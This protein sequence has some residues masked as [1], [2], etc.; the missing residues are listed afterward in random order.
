MK[1]VGL[2]FSV[3]F[4]SFWISARTLSPVPQQTTN[5]FPAPDFVLTAGSSSS[6]VHSLSF[7]TYGKILAVG[8]L[9]A[10]VDLW[11][12]ASRKKLRSINAGPACAISSDGRFLATGGKTIDIWDASSG[13]RIKT[14]AWKPKTGSSAID[15]LF[16]NPATTVLAV[17]VNGEGT[18]LYEI[19]S[20][21]FLTVLEN[22]QR[23]QFSSD[24][25]SLIGANAK[26]LTVWSTRDWSIIRDLSLS[27]DD[28]TSIAAY[29]EKDLVVVGIGK[30]ARL[31]YLSS[32]REIAA[33]GTASTNFGA[34]SKMGAV[35]L[36][37][38]PSGFA[39]WDI[40]GRQ[41]CVQSTMGNNTTAVSDDDRW[42]ATSASDGKSS[43]AIWDLQKAL[44]Q[45]GANS[46]QAA[47]PSATAVEKS[48]I[49]QGRSR[50]V[51]YKCGDCHGANGE[52]GPD[53]PDLTTTYMDAGM[54]SRFLDKPSPDASMK[55]MPN[56]PATHP[57][58]K[59]LVAYVVSL[60]RATKN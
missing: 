2:L 38:S 36:T 37:N 1:A 43:I 28:V 11:D 8:F 56:I 59:S 6:Q 4:L 33:L 58:N 10:R 12:V 19:P 5:S 14:L 45:C 32:A 27:S 18:S 51:D 13:K 30:S 29:P 44:R 47:G 17:S 52:G 34:F 54:I 42:L 21:K 15:N 16:F 25:A 53:G 57:D 49:D 40:S 24:G 23:A 35:I 20:G 31:L 3:L 55:G 41:L 7:S 46:P 22:T 50:Y 48:Q 26:H 39:V 9:P 60:K